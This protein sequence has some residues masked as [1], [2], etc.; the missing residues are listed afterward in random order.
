MALASGL[1][2]SA[3]KPDEVM[4]VEEVRTKPAP[5]GVTNFIGIGYNLID[6]NPEGGDMSDGGV[7]PGF[8]TTRRVFG[9][10]YDD[11]HLTS[12]LQYQVPDQ[13]VFTPRSSCVRTSEQETVYGTESYTKKISV[14]VS[15]SGNLCCVFLEISLKSQTLVSMN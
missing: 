5:V 14:D 3:L 12:D 9:L 6:G 7:D 13:V 8:L 11:E 2:Y 4:E 10:T 15:M 1:I